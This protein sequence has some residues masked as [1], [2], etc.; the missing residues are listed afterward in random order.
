MYVER[1]FYFVALSDIN[2]VASSSGQTK[3]SLKSSNINKLPSSSP[4]REYLASDEGRFVRLVATDMGRDGNGN[5]DN[6]DSFM[7]QVTD[8]NIVNDAMDSMGGGSS[9][10]H[11]GKK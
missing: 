10:I 5:I 3:P 11:H 9:N 4:L 8:K 1:V 2:T 7:Q 6:L